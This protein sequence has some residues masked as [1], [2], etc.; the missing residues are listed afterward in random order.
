MKI[1][2][3]IGGSILAPD[4]VDKNFVKKLAFFLSNLSK[5]NKIAVVVGGGAPA[6]K[7][8]K[9]AR[10]S[11]KSE[12]YCDYIG[13]L[14]TRNNANELIKALGKKANNKIPETIVD[15]GNSFGKKI[16]V[17]GGTEP[18]HSTDAVAALLAE[19]VN[20]DLLVNATNVDGVYNKDPKKNKNAKLMK[21]INIRKL[22]GIVSWESMGAGS[23]ALIDLIAV[24]VI[25]RSKIRTIIL[26]GHDLENIKNFIKGKKFKGTIVTF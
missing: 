15:A 12:A 11:G 18:G 5:K 17:M 26:N 13:I 16:L 10:N 21:R 9:K 22:Y 8:I 19:W 7:K 20:A 3:S 14:A 1:V 25:Q 6:R 4:N 23:Y 2:F 24:K